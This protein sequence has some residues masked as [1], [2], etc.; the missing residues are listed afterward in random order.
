M[1]GFVE[2]LDFVYSFFIFIEEIE[3]D[4]IT[5]MV[6]TLDMLRGWPILGTAPGGNWNATDYDVMHLL[7]Y[8]VSTAFFQVGLGFGPDLINPIEYRLFVSKYVVILCR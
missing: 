1:E 2:W 4:N 5:S 8:S 6:K 7:L 3:R